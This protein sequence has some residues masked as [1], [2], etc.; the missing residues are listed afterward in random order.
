MGLTMVNGELTFEV[1]QDRW[2]SMDASPSSPSKV[3]LARELLWNA[4]LS[5]SLSICTVARKDAMACSGIAQ[6]ACASS[7]MRCTD[8]CSWSKRDENVWSLQGS[9]GSGNLSSSL[10]WSRWCSDCQIFLDGCKHHSCPSV[11]PTI[12]V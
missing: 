6:R 8:G 9:S 10:E 11:H 3:M 1:S 2:W 4:G 12:R 5:S 7:R